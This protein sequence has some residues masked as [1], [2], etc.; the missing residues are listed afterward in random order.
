M[1]CN[2]DPDLVSEFLFSATRG[3]PN[4]LPACKKQLGNQFKEKE[5]YLKGMEGIDF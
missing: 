2:R 4:R 3:Y 1:N 5:I